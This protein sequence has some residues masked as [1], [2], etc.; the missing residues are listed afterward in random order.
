LVDLILTYYHAVRVD[1]PAVAGQLGA[2]YIIPVLYVP[3]LTITHFTAIYLLLRPQP[4]SARTV[5]THAIA[6]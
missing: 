1:L 6:S 3:L 4:K 5:V 2:A